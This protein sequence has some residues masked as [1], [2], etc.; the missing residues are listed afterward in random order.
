M[1]DQLHARLRAAIKARGL[2]YKQVAARFGV[3]P[4]TVAKWA[5]G[6]QGVHPARRAEVAK[7]IEEGK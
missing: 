6:A 2:V 4:V 7:W 3:H 1:A 5:T